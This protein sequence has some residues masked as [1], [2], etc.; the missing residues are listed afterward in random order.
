MVLS[1]M[2][3]VMTRDFF[4]LYDLE[5]DATPGTICKLHWHNE[6]PV[7]IS[8]WVACQHPIV[9]HLSDCVLLPPQASLFVFPHPVLP[10]LRRQRGKVQKRGDESGGQGMMKE[11]EAEEDEEEHEEEEEEEETQPF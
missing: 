1:T 3:P 7:S 2:N 9:E 11:E 8:L 4:A 10:R 6:M 5:F